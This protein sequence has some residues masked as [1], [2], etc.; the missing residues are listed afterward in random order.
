MLV[1]YLSKV[2]FVS[3]K[4]LYKYKHVVVI[5]DWYNINC[6]VSMYVYFMLKFFL[7]FFF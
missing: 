5:M 7:R 6:N 3:I 4:Y 1:V 2:I